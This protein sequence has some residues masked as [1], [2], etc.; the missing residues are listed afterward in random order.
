MSHIRAY[1]RLRITELPPEIE[2]PLSEEQLLRLVRAGAARIVGM[3]S[4]K[5]VNLGVE[6]ITKMIGSARG[7]SVTVGGTAITSVNDLQI[8]KMKLG[9]KANPTAPAAGDTA[10]DDPTPIFTISTLTVSYPTLTSVRISGVLPANQINGAQLTEEGIFISIPPTPT[11]KLFAKLVYATKVIG[12]GQA[13]QFDHD[14]A[15]AAT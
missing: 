3:A 7:S 14:I 8:A 10:L 6:I 4:N 5:V 15:I 13:Y 2:H 11:E 1:G 12:S 9:D